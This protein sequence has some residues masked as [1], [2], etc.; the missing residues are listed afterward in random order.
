MLMR[1]LL[2]LFIFATLSLQAQ[3]AEVD[4]RDV[5]DHAAIIAQTITAEDMSEYLGTLAS[6]AFEGRETG[7]AGNAKAAEYIAGR[8]EEFGIPPV[9]ALGSYYQEV[10]FSR[11]L[12]D[13]EKFRV[14]GLDYSFLKDFVVNP[15]KM[16][17][18]QLSVEAE[19]VLFLGYG[20]DDHTYSDY[21]GEDVAGKVILIYHGDPVD[22]DG[23][24]WVTGSMDRSE[25]SNWLDLKLAAAAAH[26]VAAVMV[27]EPDF[28]RISREQRIRIL[29]GGVMMGLPNFEDTGAPAIHLSSSL[30]EQ[31]LGKKTRKV[32]RARDKI[33]R[34]GKNKS[35]RIKADVAFDLSRSVNTTPGVNVLGY[36]QGVDTSLRDELVVI[37]AHY[38]H[39]GMRGDEIFNGADDNASG[40]SGVMEIAEAF[41][42]AKKQGLGPRRSILCMLVTGEEKGLLGSQY[43]T[44]N[45]VFPLENTIVNI[46]MDMIGR[47]DA[48]HDT[49]DYVYVIGADRMSTDLHKINETANARYTHLELDYTYNDPDDPNRFYYRSDH[50]NFV[51]NGIPAVFFFSGVHA[52]YHRPTDTVEK[53][54]FERAATIARLA[55]HTSWEL[56]NRDERIRVDVKND[57]S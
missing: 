35:V 15:E 36:I 30:V 27:V 26:D 47:Q 31:L 44:E 56:V 33:G 1:F 38:D 23:K 54:N 45:P 24:S 16:P 18:E 50:Y 46:N 43:Y 19:E 41:A 12:L 6:D 48:Q 13:V 11:V 52:D 7:T 20:I 3:Y 22:E 5:A 39:V 21:D 57:R 28:R 29:G 42:E 25:W 2:P 17:A 34:K 37:T 8:F 53:I 55:F 14:N 49:P 4:E 51:K 9:P 40:T 32:I 10:M